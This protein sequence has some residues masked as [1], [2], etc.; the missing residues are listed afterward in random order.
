MSFA[1]TTKDPANPEETKV[2]MLRAGPDGGVC[3]TKAHGYREFPE[4]VRIFS[5][6]ESNRI[7]GLGVMYSQ[8]NLLKFGMPSLDSAIDIKMSD[9]EHIVGFYGASGD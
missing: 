4:L 7:L 6:K 2:M 1:D 5:E 3:T 8:T 9:N